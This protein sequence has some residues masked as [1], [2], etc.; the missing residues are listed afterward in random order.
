M[1]N[2]LIDKNLGKATQSIIWEMKQKGLIVPEKIDS[3][4]T[5]KIINQSSYMI[6]IVEDDF[7]SA[8]LVSDNMLTNFMGTSCNRLTD[9]DLLSFVTTMDSSLFNHI[10]KTR[11]FFKKNKNAPYFFQLK[12]KD[13]NQNTTCFNGVYVP[14]LEEPTYYL[15]VVKKTDNI[16]QET[17]TKQERE[18]ALLLQKGYTRNEIAERLYISNNTVHY[19]TKNIFKKLG[20]NRKTLLPTIIL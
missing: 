8:T 9:F 14:L 10:P 18:V 1:H 12:S 5:L 11:A 17:L 20:I 19:H 3:D 6:A 2:K 4:E 16:P 7:L 15:A 13:F